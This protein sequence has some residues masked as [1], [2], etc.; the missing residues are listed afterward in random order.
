[1]TTRFIEC[2]PIITVS[3]I[4]AA[5]SFYVDVLGFSVDFDTGEVLGLLKDDVLI[6]LISQD[7]ENVRQP[8]GSSNVS[9]LTSEV[10]QLYRNCVA[11]NAEVLVTPGDRPYGQRD[12]A[13]RDPDGSVL[14]FGC[15][16]PE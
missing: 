10:D 16:L 7:S 15:A 14:S 4:T 6:L 1:V 5:K 11:A 3:D 13:I 2:N 12:F 8:P 9:F